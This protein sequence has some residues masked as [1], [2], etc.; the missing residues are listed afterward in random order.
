MGVLKPLAEPLNRRPVPKG[1]GDFEVARGQFNRGVS[2][3]RKQYASEWAARRQREAA[4]ESSIRAAVQKKREAAAAV[5]VAKRA[6]ALQATEAAGEAATKARAAKLEQSL[7]TELR[8]AERVSSMRGRWLAALE[9]D[10]SRWIPEDRI[11]AMITP[12][13]FSLKYA[14]QFERW[15]E[16]KERK[17]QLREEAR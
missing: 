4:V 7:R 5:R 10:A 8:R 13:L 6:A 16:V 17:R 11:D 14:W 1:H 9:R 15:F 12:D 3:L 2:T